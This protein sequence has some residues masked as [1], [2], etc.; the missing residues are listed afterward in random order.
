MSMQ[1]SFYRLAGQATGAVSEG[2][3]VAVRSCDSITAV[4]KEHA[5]SSGAW[6]STVDVVSIYVL[7]HMFSLFLG[8]EW[9]QH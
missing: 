6:Q 4:L 5:R 7:F 3:D 1:R 2:L 9:N 8:S